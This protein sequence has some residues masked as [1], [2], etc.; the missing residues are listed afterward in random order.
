MESPSLSD[1]AAS[2]YIF[3]VIYAKAVRNK[4]EEYY[5]EVLGKKVWSIW[6]RVP[7]GQYWVLRFHNDK[8]DRKIFNKKGDA[9]RDFEGE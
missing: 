5:S 7:D 8:I 4:L 6:G 3:Q 9:E 1:A 2:A